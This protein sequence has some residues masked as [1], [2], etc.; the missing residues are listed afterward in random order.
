MGWV[1][2]GRGQLA[3]I[4]AGIRKKSH[5]SSSSRSTGRIFLSERMDPRGLHDFR[6]A[7]VAPSGIGPGGHRAHI[8]ALG[9][10]ELGVRVD[11]EELIQAHDQI[12]RLHR[13]VGDFLAAR[14]G[15]ADDVAALEA[16]AA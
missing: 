11:P 1:T 14:V 13:P 5:G 4:V 3:S 2:A 6:D 15:L 10:G 12:A 9:V 16:A 7:C 8:G